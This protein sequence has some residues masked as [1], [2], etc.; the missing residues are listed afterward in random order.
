MEYLADKSVRLESEALHEFEVLAA[1]HACGGE[2]VVGDGRVGTTLEGSLAVVAKNAASPCEADECLRV[3]ESVNRHDAA[4]FVVREFR[5]ILVGR[6]RDGI[7]HI[8]RRGL[9][10][11]LAEIEAHVDSVFHSFA[12]AHDA[13]AADFK[14]S[15]KGVLQCTD[16]VVVGV[17]GA[18]VREMSA[19]CFQVVVEAG[20][21]RFFQLVKLFAIQ[22]PCRKAYGKLRFF[23]ESANGFANLFHVAV[24][25]GSAR[26]HDGVA[27]NACGFFLLGVIDDFV[28]AEQLVF[29]GTGVVVAALCAVLAIFGAAAAAGVHDGAE[30][31]VVAVEFFADLVRGVTEFLEVC[32]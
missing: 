5:K 20:E 17:R 23:L 8:H 28:G 25:K 9:D 15:G 32:I 12:E 21:A 24:R 2:H 10:A 7:Q 6:A 11:E 22:K 27:R 19:V 3:D 29:G 1:V 26:G 16:F 31:K 4:E 30:V 14:A 13:A 18:H